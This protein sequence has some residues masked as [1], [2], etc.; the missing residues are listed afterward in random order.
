[1][2]LQL[3][4]CAIGGCGA[5]DCRQVKAEQVLC[6]G[7][8]MLSL[9]AA[10]ACD[11]RGCRALNAPDWPQADGC[12]RGMA[13]G[14]ELVGPEARGGGETLEVEVSATKQI[15]LDK[16]L[17]MIALQSELLDLRANPDRP[18]EGTVVEAKLARG[19]GPVATVLVQRGTL[20]V[21]DVVV[22]G[23]EFGRVRALITDTGANTDQA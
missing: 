18:A 11:A 16:L 14:F 21:G 5:A 10:S 1:M 22:A 23:A 4:R 6:P 7:R 12:Q 2:P 15:N 9:L 8:C 19:R 20:K 17:E 3:R 13:A